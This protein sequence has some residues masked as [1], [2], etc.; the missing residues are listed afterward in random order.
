MIRLAVSDD[1]V[2]VVAPGAGPMNTT[3]CSPT[4]SWRSENAQD[5]TGNVQQRHS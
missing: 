2:V 5:L 3:T 1:V 4:V